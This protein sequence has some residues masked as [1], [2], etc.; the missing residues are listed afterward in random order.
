MGAV[1]LQGGERGALAASMTFLPAE[2]FIVR[3]LFKAAAVHPKLGHHCI[4][5]N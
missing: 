5:S 2:P 1:V 3:C 4:Y